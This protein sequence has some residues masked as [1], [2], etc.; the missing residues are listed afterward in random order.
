MTGTGWTFA[1]LCETPVTVVWD[2]L[3]YWSE[4]PPSH[5]LERAHVKFDSQRRTRKKRRAVTPERIAAQEQKDASGRVLGT[6]G[7]GHQSPV[8]AWVLDARKNVR[9]D[10]KKGRKG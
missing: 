8:P 9:E 3:D 5:I 10:L 7:K 1:Q 4:Y 2:L 6:D